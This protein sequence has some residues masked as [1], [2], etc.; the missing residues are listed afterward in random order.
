[1]SRIEKNGYVHGF[2]VLLKR[3]DGSYMWGSA[4]AQYY[5]DKEGHLLGIEGIIRDISE[6]KQAEA[7]KEVDEP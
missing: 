7:D 2:E 1:M 6:R 5:T 4:S 3:F